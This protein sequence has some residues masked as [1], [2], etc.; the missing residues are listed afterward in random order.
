LI[1]ANGYLVDV[2]TLVGYD[3]TP[4]PVNIPDELTARASVYDDPVGE[5]RLKTRDGTMIQ[6]V[7]FF[8]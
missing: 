6:S 3:S 4:V 1:V 5:Q 2:L 7:Y 8:R